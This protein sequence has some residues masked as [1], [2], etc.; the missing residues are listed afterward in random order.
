MLIFD[1]ENPT[2]DTEWRI[3]YISLP[4]FLVKKVILTKN[5]IQSLIYDFYLR[6][7]FWAKAVHYFVLAEGTIA[8]A[9]LGFPSE[10]KSLI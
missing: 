2:V 5:E 1:L 6:M 7:I 9:P 4:F 8:I 10:R 3:V